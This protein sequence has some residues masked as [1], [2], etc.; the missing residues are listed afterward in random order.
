M[1]LFYKM[2]YHISQN[3]ISVFCNCANIVILCRKQQK[4]ATNHYK[5]KP[6]LGQGEELIPLNSTQTAAKDQAFNNNNTISDK[7]DDVIDSNAVSVVGS[8]QKGAD[9]HEPRLILAVLKSVWPL[10]LQ[11][12]ALRGMEV[13]LEFVGPMLLK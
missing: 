8:A 7:G 9:V 1:V 5:P 6:Q 10:L 4:A 3:L 13:A 11:A 12:F 2:C